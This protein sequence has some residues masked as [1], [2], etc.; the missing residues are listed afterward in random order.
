VPANAAFEIDV[1]VDDWPTWPD[2][3]D[4]PVLTHVEI[5]LTGNGRALWQ[6]VRETA[7]PQSDEDA[8]RRAMLARAIGAEPSSWLDYL[9]EDDPRFAQLLETAGAVIGLRGILTEAAYHA[10]D[11]ANVGIVQQLPTAWATSLCP[12]LAH[13]PSILAWASTAEEL[14]TLPATNRSDTFGR[15]WIVARKP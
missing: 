9:A 7:P 14:A 5:R 8:P 6:T 12:R 3:L 11:R 10:L 4:E 2:P 13:H 1:P 15:P